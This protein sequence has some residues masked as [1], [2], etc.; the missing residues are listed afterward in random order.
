MRSTNLGLKEDPDP[1]HKRS[2]QEKVGNLHL[3]EKEE[4]ARKEEKVKAR[5]KERSLPT[6]SLMQECNAKKVPNAPEE[7]VVATEPVD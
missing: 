4:K 5:V 1:L 2:R 6:Q 3:A 7:R